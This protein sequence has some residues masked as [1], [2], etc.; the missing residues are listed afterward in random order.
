MPTELPTDGY[1]AVRDAIDSSATQP[2]QWDYIGFF[3]DGG[4]EV[5]RISITGDSRCQWAH[6][7]GS[8][9]LEVIA[10][11]SGSDSDVPTP[12][13]FAETKLFNVSGVGNGTALSTDTVTNETVDADSDSVS[14]VHEVEVP[15]I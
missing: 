1:Q 12:T 14:I 11:L 7:A 9:P 10:D 5:L 4:S 8:N 13:T 3:D 6:T 15:Q 2:D